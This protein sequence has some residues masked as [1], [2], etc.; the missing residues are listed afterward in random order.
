MSAEVSTQNKKWVD[1]LNELKRLENELVNHIKDCDGSNKNGLIPVC[2]A[3][4]VISVQRAKDLVDR[5]WFKLY[6]QCSLRDYI[7]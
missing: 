1:A 3:D 4:L 5:E 6:R 2:C 7:H